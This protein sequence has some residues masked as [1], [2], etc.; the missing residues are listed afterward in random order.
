VALPM[1]ET[2][3]L[4]VNLGISKTKIVTYSLVPLPE[5]D[6]NG[7]V[8][9]DSN[10]NVVYQTNPDGSLV[11]YRSYYSPAPI[12]DYINNLGHDT[13]HNGRSRPR[14]RTTRVTVTSTRPTVRCSSFR[15]VLPARLDRAVLQAHLQVRPVPAGH[16]FADVPGFCDAR[17]RQQLR[18]IKSVLPPTIRITSPTCRACRSSRTSTPA[19]F[20]TCATSATTPW[21]RIRSIQAACPSAMR[22][23]AASR[24]AATSRPSRR[25]N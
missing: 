19:A 10:G 8:V 24:L 3:S 12:V 21:A 5:I 15:R 22:I 11:Y 18:N 17:L 4:N 13:F 25:P 7:N 20:P 23:I 2:D 9:L 1:T 14:G 16:R 6:S